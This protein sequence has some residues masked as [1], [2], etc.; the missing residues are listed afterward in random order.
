MGEFKG[1]LVSEGAVVLMRQALDE[2]D[3]EFFGAFGGDREDAGAV[4]VSGLA[5]DDARVDHL[6]LG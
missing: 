3:A 1:E 6:A 5:L 2:S 4:D